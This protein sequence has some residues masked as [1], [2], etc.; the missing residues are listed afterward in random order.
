MDI[1]HPNDVL[2][3]QDEDTASTPTETAP[4]M[5]EIFKQ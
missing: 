5:N 4:G 1:E 2:T 3:N